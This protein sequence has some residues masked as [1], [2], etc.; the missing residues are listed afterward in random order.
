MGFELTVYCN[1]ITQSGSSFWVSHKFSIYYCDP[2][3][4]SQLSVIQPRAQEQGKLCKLYP[5]V[6]KWTIGFATPQYVVSIKEEHSRGH[7]KP[8]AIIFTL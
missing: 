8:E 7:L 6:Y 3:K 1:I 4:L 2:K 5:Y